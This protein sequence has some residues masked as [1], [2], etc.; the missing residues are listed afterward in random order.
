MYVSVEGERENMNIETFWSHMLMGAHDQ[1][2]LDALPHKAAKV[3]FQKYK[4]YHSL[5]LFKTSVTYLCKQN[6]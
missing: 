4:K 3:L 6:T 1:N 2:G 5:P